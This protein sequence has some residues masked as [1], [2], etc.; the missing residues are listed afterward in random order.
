MLDAGEDFENKEFGVSSGAM[1][2]PP[3][4][5]QQPAPQ[6]VGLTIEPPP[7]QDKLDSGDL[8]LEELAPPERQPD[9]LAALDAMKS[10]DEPFD[11]K[12][13]APPIVTEPLKRPTVPEADWHQ[14]QQ[15]ATP[16]LPAPEPPGPRPVFARPPWDQP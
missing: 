6:P 15:E 8:D 14:E 12:P 5:E 11:P 13:W 7:W 9:E 10:V 16:P 1:L 4:H 3:E 2:P